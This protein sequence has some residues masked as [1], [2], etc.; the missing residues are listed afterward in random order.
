MRWQAILCSADEQIKYSKDLIHPVPRSAFNSLQIAQNFCKDQSD[1]RKKLYS[2]R[3]D[4][5]AENDH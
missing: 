2:V 5:D 4:K 3:E 1:A